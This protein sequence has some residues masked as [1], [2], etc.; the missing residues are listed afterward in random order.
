MCAFSVFAFMSLFVF[1]VNGDVYLHNPRGNNNRCDELSNNRNNANR[2]FDSQNNAAGGYAVPCNRP[3]DAK[4]DDD[5]DCYTMKYY[6]DTVI[7]IRWTSQHNCGE[8]NDCQFILQYA[9]EGDLGINIRN[10]HPQNI[11]G[12]TCTKI[13]PEKTDRQLEEDERISPYQYGKNEDFSYYQRCKERERNPFLFTAD[14]KLKGNSALYTR[15]NPNG[16]RYGFECPEERDY[17]PYWGESDWRDIAVLTTDTNRCP[18]YE[19]NSRCNSEKHECVGGTKFVTTSK[20]CET[21]GGIWHTYPKHENCN[22]TCTQ[23]PDAPINRLGSGVDDSK[24]NTF[25]WKLPNVTKQNCVLRIRYN[26]STRETPWDFDVNDNDKLKNNPVQNTSHGVPVRVAVNTA[27]YG[28]T[29][30]DRTYTFDIIERP[31]QLQEKTI[32]NVNVQGKR[33]NIAQVRNCIE[34]DFVPNNLYISEDDYLHFQFIGSDYNP[35]GND[36]EG[37]AGTDRSN[38]VIIESLKDNMPSSQNIETSSQ[39]FEDETMYQLAT[40]DQ[41]IDNNE[42]CYNFEELDKQN[43]RND[44]QSHKNCA[45]LNRAEPYFNMNPVKPTKTGKMKAM[46]S[47]NNNFSNR[48]QKLSL[49]VYSSKNNDNKD[50]KDNNNIAKEKNKNNNVSPYSVGVIIGITICCAAIVFTI[51]GLIKHDCHKK[52]KNV[53]KVIRQN[54]ASYI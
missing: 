40:I 15:Q 44:K 7:P 23:A 30:E 16:N 8:N 22:L 51:V 10:G 35:L 2:L 52:I 33:G 4:N 9:C 1:N 28:R 46:C 6:T 18:Y 24:H 14:Q 47:R 48:G 21:H 32:H 19:K 54:T 34:Y 37:R 41:P 17:Y 20:D 29:F 50:N 39:L 13:I 11:N 27:Q 42:K 38:V 49:I 26:I 31:T 43:K 3:E 5:I 45:L 12:N 36:G 25:Y 53:P